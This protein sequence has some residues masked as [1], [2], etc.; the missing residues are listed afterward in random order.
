MFSTTH[1]AIL[2]LAIIEPDADIWFKIILG[3]HI[4]ISLKQLLVYKDWIV[5]N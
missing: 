2:I 4:W 3:N 1:D 5:C